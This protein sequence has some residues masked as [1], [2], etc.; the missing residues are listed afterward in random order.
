[1]SYREQLDAITR[2]AKDD[3]IGWDLAGG[4]LEEGQVSPL[5]GY[6]NTLFQEVEHISFLLHHE[7]FWNAEGY[8]LY[9]GRDGRI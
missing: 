9:C 3:H 8:C 2:Q 5:R 6:L 1:M 4:D 7:H